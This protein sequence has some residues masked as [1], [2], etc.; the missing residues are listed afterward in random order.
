MLF[1]KTV[2]LFGL[3]SHPRPLT[4]INERLSQ[5]IRKVMFDIRGSEVFQYWQSSGFPFI[6][7]PDSQTSVDIFIRNNYAEN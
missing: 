2:S 3:F 7:I 4:A 1:Q 6:C 5:N